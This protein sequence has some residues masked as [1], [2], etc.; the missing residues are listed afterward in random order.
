MKPDEIRSEL[1]DLVLQLPTDAL[2][3][4]HRVLSALCHYPGPPQLTH[5]GNLSLSNTQI[6]TLAEAIEPFLDTPLPATDCWKDMDD[7]ELWFYVIAQVC[8]VGKADGADRV[9]QDQLAQ[10]QLAWDALV[11]LEDDELQEIIWEALRRNGVRYVAADLSKD[12]KSKALT[13]NLRTLEEYGG[14]KG[15]FGEIAKFGSDEDR[16]AEVMSD[17]AY[18]KDKGARDLLVELGMV[19]D[20]VALDIRVQNVLEALG[21][22]TSGLMQGAG[23][24][25][26]EETLRAALPHLGV[27]SLA[28]LDRILFGHTK[29]IIAAIQRTLQDDIK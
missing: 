2:D 25:A 3:A 22:R 28:H 23:Y 18:I 13:R 1:Q 21:F 19:E 8:V 20:V 4:A 10:E 16:V 27:S 15:Y 5:S 24:N 29:E 26:V 9:R 12:N 6:A 7:N 17:L 11:G 14:P